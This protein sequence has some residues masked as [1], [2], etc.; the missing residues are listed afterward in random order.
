VVAASNTPEHPAV[1]DAAAK[2][3]AAQD[4][5]NDTLLAGLVLAGW[6]LMRVL[7]DLLVLKQGVSQHK[8]LC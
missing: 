7:M 6:Q 8:A 3:A 5:V 4:V 1:P 2:P